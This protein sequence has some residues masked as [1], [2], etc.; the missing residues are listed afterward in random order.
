MPPLIATAVAD[1]FGNATVQMPPVGPNV[2]IE[3]IAVS[4]NS[5][6]GTCKV[7]LNKNFVLG[8]SQAWADS[9]DGDP[10]IPVGQND[11]L[12]VVFS[13]AGN[14]VICKAAFFGTQEVWQ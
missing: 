13:G 12:E 11:I 1:F 8:S 2:I 4:T 10:P 14:G 7:F 6:G 5:V 3:Q 9:A